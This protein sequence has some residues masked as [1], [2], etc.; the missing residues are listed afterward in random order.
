MTNWHD[1]KVSIFGLGKSGMLSIKKLVGLN[2]KVFATDSSEE[3][4]KNISIRQELDSLGV[5]YEFGGHTSKSID[6]AEL[7][8]LSPGVNPNLAILDDARKMNIPIISEIELASRFIS[9]P[10]I[11]V[12]GTNGKTTTTTLIYEMIKQSGKRAIAAGNIGLPLIAIDD[13]QYDFIVAE[14]SSYQ[15]ETIVAFRP[16]I[17]LILNI[18]EDHMARHKTMGNYANTKARIFLNQK[19]NDYVIYNADDINVV[20]LAKLSEARQVP[21]HR[22]YYPEYL[23]IPINEMKIKG[24]HNV[25]NAA[26]ATLA[27]KIAGVSSSDIAQVLRT[28]SGVEHRIEFVREVSG[29]S[30]YNDSKATNPDSTIVAL[31]ALGSN[32]KNIVLLL[33]GRDKNGDLDLMCSKIKDSAKKVILLGEAADRFKSGLIKNGFNEFVVAPDF[34]DAVKL[35]FAFSGPKD[36]VLLSPAC[37]S[38]DMFENY[39]DRGRKFKELVDKL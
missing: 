37:A 12:T 26:A 23:P 39:E 17:S 1:K 13:S 27:A 16:W 3:S 11:A 14:I 21:F 31:K 22:A 30:F 2:A 29:V 9:K 24:E 25:Q 38:F 28:F 20:K 33:G 6:G 4:E 8:V 36:I 34:P 18:T 32:K 19:K 15:L 10:I 5:K 35:A 7:I